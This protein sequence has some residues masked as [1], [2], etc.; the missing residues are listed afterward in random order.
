MKKMLL[1]LCAVVALALLLPRTYVLASQ[2]I[3]LPSEQE[4]IEVAEG[5]VE[6]FQLIVASGF[7][8]QYSGWAYDALIA[9]RDIQTKIGTYGG[10]KSSTAVIGDD[11]ALVTVEVS[12]SRLNAVVTFHLYYDR[13]PEVEIHTRF[14]LTTLMS[15]SGLDVALPL[16]NTAAIIVII[17][18]LCVKLPKKTRK[19][20]SDEAVTDSIDGS[21]A[22]IIKSEELAD[23]QGEDEAE[24]EA[25]VEAE[26]EAETTAE[27]EDTATA[28]TVAETETE[29]DTE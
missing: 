19:G 22:Y 2:D 6:N 17:I 16:I 20:G 7:E 26:V 8:E 11:K 18:V 13:E 14:S 12:G 10:I 15:N 28:E 21:I 4:A 24:K 29:T 27:P 25:E 3:I 23:E 9:W 5:F 1:T